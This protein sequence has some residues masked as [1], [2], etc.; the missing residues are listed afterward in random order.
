[1]SSS[2]FDFKHHANRG[3]K[4]IWS[5]LPT[6]DEPRKVSA[7]ERADSIGC[8]RLKNHDEPRGVSYY[9]AEGP[10]NDISKRPR[11]HSNLCAREFIYLPRSRNWNENQ[12]SNR[13]FDDIATIN[14]YYVA[15]EDD[16]GI[17][18]AAIAKYSWQWRIPMHESAE[19]GLGFSD[20]FSL[21]IVPNQMLPSMWKTRK[22]SKSSWITISWR[23]LYRHH[24]LWK[25]H[26]VWRYDL[27]SGL[28]HHR[29]RTSGCCP[30]DQYF[31]SLGYLELPAMIKTVILITL[32]W[33]FKKEP[34]E[35]T[36][37][38]AWNWWNKEN[39]WTVLGFNVE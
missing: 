16:W 23:A 9:I 26:P 7:H 30:G 8:S 19:P 32:Q 37:P 1:M 22:G 35:L 24:P 15:K 5:V 18:L 33:L 11:N 21:L 13:G 29:L 6:A 2:I 25:Y 28:K 12:V 38:N 27:M 3:E 34:S 36:L 4:A 31:K 17:V 10:V 14:G 39:L 20:E